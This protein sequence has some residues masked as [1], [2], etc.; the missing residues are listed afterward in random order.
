MTDPLEQSLRDA[1]LERAAQIDPGARARLRAIDY[2]P[3]DRRHVPLVS[4]LGAGGLAAAAAVIAAV[5][6]TGGAAPAFAGWKA[7]PTAPAP[8]QL[9]QAQQVCAGLGTPVLTDT[10]GPYTVSIYVGAGAR[11]VCLTGNGISMESSG[12]G[13]SGSSIGTGQVELGEHGLQDS[14]GNALVI[15]DG[16]VGSGVTAVTIDRVDG[17]SVQASVTDGWYLA[18]WPGNVVAA[19]VEVTTASGTSTESFPARPV[20]SAPSCPAGAKCSSG[21]GFESAPS[22]QATDGS[23][24]TSIQLS[25]GTGPG[26]TTSGQ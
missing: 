1:L 26:S 10:R 7:T 19:G 17:S 4:A 24:T 12:A 9:A 21:F 13:T 16:E 6:L 14:S 25:G 23:Q 15:V 2:R 18:W 22:G 20:Q 5:E 3:R 11:H 8:G